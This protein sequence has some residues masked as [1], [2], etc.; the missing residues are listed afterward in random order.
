MKITHNIFNGT[1]QNIFLIILLIWDK[2][3]GR[4][5]LTNDLG[6]DFEI[7]DQIFNYNDLIF[8]DEPL[9]P[10]NKMD[11]NQLMIVNSEIT[12]DDHPV[13]VPRETKFDLPESE[14][15]IENK[16]ENA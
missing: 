15:M 13:K 7:N 9:V 10:K 5:M 11:N 6:Q 8:H 4:Y 3:N 16:F 1:V 14:G 12:K 2:V